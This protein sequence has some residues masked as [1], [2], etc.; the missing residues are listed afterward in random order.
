VDETTG[1]VAASIPTSTPDTILRMVHPPSDG[2][3]HVVLD[4][5]P[6][7]AA[8]DTSVG[9]IVGQ[10]LIF[11]CRQKCGSVTTAGLVPGAWSSL[12]EEKWN[13]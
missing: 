5:S 2:E 8:A 7:L 12:D 6:V 10:P 1:V 4:A 11:R 13:A 9:G 3:P